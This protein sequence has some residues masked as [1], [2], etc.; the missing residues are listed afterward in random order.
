MQVVLIIVVLLLVGLVVWL[1][2]R[3]QQIEKTYGA[4]FRNTDPKPVMRALNDYANIITTH[5]KQ[6][7]VLKSY[8]DETTRL[9][10]RAGTR[11]GFVRFN[12]FQ[13][14]GGDQS[15]CLAIIDVRGD[16]YILSSIHARTGTRVYAKQ[17]KHGSSSH[18]LSDE[19]ATAL[20]K[21]QKQNPR[22][23]HA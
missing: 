12:P 4:F 7:D 20:T 10:E 23:P 1:L 18:N 14:T 3:M 6:I 16:G 15:F 8:L 21:A 2:I 13:D 19:E 5:S 11:I 17:I 9:S 22:Q